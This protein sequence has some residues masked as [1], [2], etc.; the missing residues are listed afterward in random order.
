[1]KTMDSQKTAMI[2]KPMVMKTMTELKAD[3]AAIKAALK[4]S[5]KSVPVNI[6]VPFLE[7]R[8]RPEN[9]QDHCCKDRKA[10]P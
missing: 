2:G 7:L 6:G 1:M 8:D 3:Y 4:A 10:K 9:N 5:A